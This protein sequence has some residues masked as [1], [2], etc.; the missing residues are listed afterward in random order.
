M[1]RIL[2]VASS[3]KAA[4]SIA[5]LVRDG[6][7]YEISMASSGSLARR[8]VLE[9]EWDTVV[10]NHPLKDDDAERF[11][12]MVSEHS[13]ATALILV[14]SEFVKTVSA[15]LG[16]IAIIVEKPVVRPLLHQAM[17]IGANARSR[18]AKLK[19]DNARLQARLEDLKYINQAKILLVVNE[20]ISEEQAHRRIERMA[21]DSRIPR[22]EAAKTIIRLYSD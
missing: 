3:D 1:E 7:Q 16:N 20:H 2:V 6:G 8:M 19:L 14:K 5:D 22:R 17:R 4:Q 12:Q 10:V 9:E 18:I 11:I 15:N 21:M 13:D